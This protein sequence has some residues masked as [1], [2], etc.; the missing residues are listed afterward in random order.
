MPVP[1]MTYLVDILAF[2]FGDQLVKTLIIGF[3]ADGA[4]DFLDV[5]GGWGSV[6]TKTEE[7]V[8]CEML[9]FGDVSDARQYD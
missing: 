3:Y 8:S 1:R 7:K 2:E 5:R 4:E 6:S 9:H